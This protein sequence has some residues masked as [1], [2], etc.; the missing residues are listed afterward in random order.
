MQDHNILKEDKFERT[1]EHEPRHKF[2][3]FYTHTFPSQIFW[4]G[5]IFIVFFMILRKG[6]LPRIHNILVDRH[7][8]ISNDLI[9]AARLKKESDSLLEIYE[10]KLED[11][12]LKAKLITHDAYK[13]SKERLHFARE[14]A[15]KEFGVKISECQKNINTMKTKA[16]AEINVSVEELT[17][18]L[19][20]KLTGLSVPKSEIVSVVSKL[21]K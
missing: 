19:I 1:V 13:N 14:T 15:D 17:M 5:I 2:P 9:E 21:I 4:L 16:L 18:E 7:D 20:K 10:K 8:K 12:R 11:A 6:I 3:P